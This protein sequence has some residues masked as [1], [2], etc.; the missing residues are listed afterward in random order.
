[1][2]M[3]IPA[4]E[5]PT[6][7]LSAEYTVIKIDPPRDTRPIEYARPLSNSVRFAIFLPNEWCKIVLVLYISIGYVAIHDTELQ[8]APY[9][10]GEI[11]VFV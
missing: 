8:I 3:V 11:S 9:T 1:M 4:H 7:S 2:A 5:K 10:T 6:Y